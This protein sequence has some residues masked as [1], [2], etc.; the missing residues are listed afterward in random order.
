MNSLKPAPSRKPR[1]WRAECRYCAL[2][3]I[4]WVMEMRVWPGLASGA[5]AIWTVSRA[6]GAMETT[7]PLPLA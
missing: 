1:M 3:S 2:L 7:T 4:V 5:M 6:L